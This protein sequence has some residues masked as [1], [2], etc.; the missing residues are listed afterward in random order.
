MRNG[1]LYHVGF[2]MQ[3]R[4]ANRVVHS[5]AVHMWNQYLKGKLYLIQR[6]RSLGVWEYWAVRSTGGRHVESNPS[7]SRNVTRSRHFAK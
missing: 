6:K 2:L 1:E 5:I 7:S 4:V 3:D